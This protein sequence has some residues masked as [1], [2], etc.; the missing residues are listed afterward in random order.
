MSV[1]LDY[2]LVRPFYML[3]GLA[4]EWFG[5]TAGDAQKFQS[6]MPEL[7]VPRDYPPRFDLY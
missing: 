4:P 5:L 3:S 1:I 6:H 2:A 7:V